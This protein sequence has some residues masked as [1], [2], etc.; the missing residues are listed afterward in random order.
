[1]SCFHNIAFFY[2]G[3]L[4]NKC[5]EIILHSEHKFTL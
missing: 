5:S 4:D 2:K 3:K 1:M